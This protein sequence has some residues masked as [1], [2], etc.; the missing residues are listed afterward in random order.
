MLRMQISPAA[1]EK[2]TYYII[3]TSARIG[4]KVQIEFTPES[5]LR[6]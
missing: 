4:T 3:V 6:G 5:S 2:D 1:E